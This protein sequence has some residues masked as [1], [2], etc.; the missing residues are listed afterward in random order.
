MQLYHSKK[1]GLPELVAKFT[2]APARLLRLQKGT[3]AVGADADV[4]VFDL[5]RNGYLTSRR[6]RVSFQQPILR[7]A[8]ERQGCMTVVGEH[9]VGKGQEWARRLT[10]INI[11]KKTAI[12]LLACWTVAQAGAAELEWLTFLPKAQERPRPRASSF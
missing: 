1:L 2:V 3:L 9:C 5:E 4:T 11:M 6:V 7:L 10:S 8:L 12:A